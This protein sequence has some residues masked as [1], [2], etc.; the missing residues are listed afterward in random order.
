MG[1]NRA[2]L[3]SSLGGT[4]RYHKDSQPA[5]DLIVPREGVGGTVWSHA[6]WESPWDL[7]GPQGLLKAGW[8]RH[9]S[10]PC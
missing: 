4:I 8:S 9:C 2:S 6:D 10:I 7:K 5:W 3:K 1:P